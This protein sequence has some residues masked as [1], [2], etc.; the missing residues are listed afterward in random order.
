MSGCPLEGQLQL[1]FPT[2]EVA[3][4]IPYRHAKPYEDMS[5]LTDLY[6][7]KGWSLGRISKELGGCK[8]TV[9]K[10]LVEAGIE[11]K[12]EAGDDYTVLNKKI[13]TMRVR[14]LT[15]QQ[16]ADLPNLW[17]V[18][19][20]TCPGKWHSKTVGEIERNSR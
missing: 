11:I 13:Q 3:E 15:Y 5:F 8:A 2:I 4:I 9:K 12:V 10:K 6:L 16:I 7:K 1:F 14:G 18:Q 19:K 17:G 20:R